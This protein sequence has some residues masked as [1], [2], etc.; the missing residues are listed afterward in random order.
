MDS[1]AKREGSGGSKGMTGVGHDSSETPVDDESA[2]AS[3]ETTGDAAVAAEEMTTNEHGHGGS[4]KQA[5]FVPRL[6]RGRPPFQ[7]R[8]TQLRDI[9]TRD[10]LTQLQNRRFF[11]ERLQEELKNAERLRK[12]LSLAMIDVDDLKANHA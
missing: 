1:R 3:W 11:Y 6:G 8:Q 7:A 10:D 12:P 4:I 9:A 5:V 2:A